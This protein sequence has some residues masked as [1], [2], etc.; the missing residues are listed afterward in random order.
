MEWM[1]EH[2]T[3]LWWVSAVSLAILVTS[4]IAGP[5]WI[6]RIPA[7][8][9]ADDDY[10][11]PAPR[12]HRLYP[13]VVVL[14]NVLGGT[15]ALAGLLMIVLPGPGL[16]VILIGISLMSFPGKYR[17][18]RWMVS[19]PPLLKSINWLRRRAGRAPLYLEED[20]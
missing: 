9:F 1:Q 17:L 5:W 3:I 14:R 6:A 7:D 12:R 19:R 13:L 2:A 16:L 18:V 10:A 20:D 15:L 8:Y 11:Q 4:M